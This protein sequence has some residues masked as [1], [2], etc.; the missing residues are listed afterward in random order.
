[1]RIAIDGSAI[2]RQ[3][4][5]AGV[6]TYQLI[7]A[8]AKVETEHEFVTFARGGL[9]DDLPDLEVINIRPMPPPIRLA[10]EQVVLPV[11]LR[12]RGIDLLHSPHHHTPTIVLPGVS[13]VVTFNDITFMLLPDRYPRVRRMYMN[14]V[15]RAAARL[16]SA[17]ITP[18]E[19]VRTDVVTKLN[20][21][22]NIIVVPD[23]AG[24]QYTPATQSEINRV[25]ERY[26]IQGSYILSVSSLEPGKNRTRLIEAFAQARADH[27][28]VL[29]VIVGQPAWDYAG[30]SDVVKRLDL[31]QAVRFTGYVPDED[32]PPLYSGAEML[33]Y[34]SLYEG[35][36]LPILEA[37]ACDTPVITSDVGATAEVASDAALLV[38]PVDVDSIASAITR[39]LGDDQLRE[40]LRA[41]GRIR[42]GKFSWERTAKE[43]LAV[44]EQALA[45]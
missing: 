33:A 30:D 15:T 45:K 39:L 18:S 2:P 11:L 35:F 12:R 29:L 37:M 10:W 21:E 41:K 22:S 34:P 5:G 40:S 17:I 14:A 26:D 20:P 8:L 25:R 7:R 6:Y 36:G 13:R 42:A 1:M 3:M 23:A 16:A 38:D 28:S 24:P 31:E 43:T 27:P 9:F 4:A 44:Y 19:A 32:L